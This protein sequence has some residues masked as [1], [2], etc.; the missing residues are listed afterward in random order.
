MK[1]V[2]KREKT[3]YLDRLTAL[4]LNGPKGGER[5]S[6][7][8]KGRPWLRRR[9]RRRRPQWRKRL[10]PKTVIVAK[11]ERHDMSNMMTSGAPI[12]PSVGI[13]S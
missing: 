7:A 9:R 3:K 2:L 6:R 5:N 8:G 13:L 4:N 12:D 10:P 1:L 11:V